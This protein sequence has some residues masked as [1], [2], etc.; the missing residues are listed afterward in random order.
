[1]VFNDLEKA[2]DK[3]TSY[4]YFV[5]YKRKKVSLKVTLRSL[6]RCLWLQRQ[7]REQL[8]LSDGF[9]VIYGYASKVHQTPHLFADKRAENNSRYLDEMWCVLFDVLLIDQIRAWVIK[10]CYGGN[11]WR[12]RGLKIT[13]TKTECTEC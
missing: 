8:G 7:V 12:I 10:S 6:K 11:L 9:Q 4:G 1:M 13:R 3:S 5:G 2:Y